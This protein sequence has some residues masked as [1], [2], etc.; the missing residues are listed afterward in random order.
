MPI[1]PEL[2]I[3]TFNT[4]PYQSIPFH[5]GKDVNSLT[6]LLLSSW[7][8]EAVDCIVLLQ[9]IGSMPPWLGYTRSQSS[10]SFHRLPKHSIA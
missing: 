1:W 9:Q 2:V 4:R 7:A 5:P 10:R 8:I 3:Y 6:I